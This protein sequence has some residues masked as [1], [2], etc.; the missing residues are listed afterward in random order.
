MYDTGEQTDDRQGAM[1]LSPILGTR[2]ATP[3]HYTGNN[4]NINNIHIRWKHHHN[5]EKEWNTS[6][7]NKLCYN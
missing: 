7:S 3:T 4:T 6:C 5:Q 2:R 1:P